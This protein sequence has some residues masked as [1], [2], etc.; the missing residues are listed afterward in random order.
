M[1]LPDPDDFT[2]KVPVQPGYGFELFRHCISFHAS[3]YG[4]VFVQFERVKVLADALPTFP[5]PSSQLV[6]LAI[7]G[8]LD[9]DLSR[10]RTFPQKVFK[11]SADG[12]SEKS[13]IN[14][15]EDAAFSAAQRAD[16]AVEASRER[17]SGLYVGADVLELNHFNPH[18]SSSSMVCLTFSS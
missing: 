16:E 6:S 8:E 10:V 2:P 12:V 11:A 7:L 15:V 3:Q 9:G 18:L 5:E 1:F 14:S 17:H 13:K 4:L